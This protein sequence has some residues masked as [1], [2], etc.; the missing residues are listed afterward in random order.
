VSYKNARLAR[1]QPHGPDLFNLKY[2]THSKVNYAEKGE[3]SATRN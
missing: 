3:R 2:A 1:S